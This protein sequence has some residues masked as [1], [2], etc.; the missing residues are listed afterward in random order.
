[1]ENNWEKEFQS[2]LYDREYFIQNYCTFFD[3][4]GNL[5]KPHQIEFDLKIA[6]EAKMHMFIR[7]FRSRDSK[8]VKRKIEH[9][10]LDQLSRDWHYKNWKA[11]TP[12]EKLMESVMQELGFWPTTEEKILTRP[13]TYQEMEDFLKMKKHEKT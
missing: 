5:R 4:D 12:A 11:E 1:M 9:V 2:C 3:E 7:S 6:I 13:D 8:I 10:F